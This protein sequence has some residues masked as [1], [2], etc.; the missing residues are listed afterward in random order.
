M[1]DGGD[2][3]IRVFILDDHEMVRRGIREVLSRQP[4]IEVT[5]EAGTVG[6]AVSQVPALAVDVAVLDVQLPD[7]TGVQACQQIRAASPDT[8]CLMITGYTDEQAMLAAIQAGAAG[9]VSKL[10]PGKDLIEAVRVVA[11]GGSVLGPDALQ[12]VMGRLRAPAPAADPLAALTTQETRV[13]RLIG[14]GMTNRQIAAAMF[15]SEKTVKNYVSALLAK[16]GLQ[17]RSQAAVMITR[18]GDQPKTP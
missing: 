5:G 15:L 13:L 17:H 7:G 11:A 10:S 14:E 8:G 1:A 12:S 16:L 2:R 9:F 18:L 4:D 6:A 3:K